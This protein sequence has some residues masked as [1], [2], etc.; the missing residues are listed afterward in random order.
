VIA[1]SF[2]EASGTYR[3]ALVGL[4][5]ILFAMT[6]VVNVSAR[7]VVHRAEVRLRGAG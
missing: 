6:I 5:V 3:A 2:G 4:G 7:L 1:N